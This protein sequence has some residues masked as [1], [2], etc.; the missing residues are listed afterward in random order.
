MKKVHFI[1]PL[2]LLLLFVFS[3]DA[4]AQEKKE[5]KVISI[6][7]YNLENLFDTINDVELEN[8]DEFTPQGNKQW[9]TSRYQEK[10]NNMAYAI[11][12]IAV[13]V[14][15]DGLALLG[16]SEMENR[17]V[18]EDLVKQK[19]IRGRN[20]QIVHF[21]SSD[22]RGIDVALIY[23]PNYFKVTNSKTYPLRMAEDTSWRT[24]DQLV[25]SGLLEGEEIT[26]IVNHWPS[27]SG[28]ATESEPKRIA[29][30]DLCRHIVDSLL[31]L[32]KNA[33]ILVLGDLNDNPDNPS[34]ENHLRAK[35]DL[36][37]LE[38]G[39]LYNPMYKMYKNG[40]GS[41][42]YKKIWDLFDQI[43]ISQGF[44]GKGKSKYKFDQ[45][46]VFDIDFLKQ[47]DGEYAGYPLRTFGGRAYLNGYSDHFPVFVNLVKTV[48]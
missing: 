45:A 21:E 31:H 1:L 20:Y 18:L 47:K 24:R 19:A 44:L 32:D 12:Q 2:V 29:A 36:S 40:I 22:A 14:T 4:H 35:G 11:S 39:D 7:F 23:Q 10:L 26:V 5:Y 15:P 34:V 46:Y 3:Q 13:D 43:V 25:V 37:Q 9:T 38:E 30:G 6:G 33:K 8:S 17:G 42:E 41:L 28:G 27:R 48:K 16:L